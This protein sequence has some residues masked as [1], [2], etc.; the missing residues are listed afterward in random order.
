MK[1]LPRFIKIGE[2]RINIDEI[3]CY[4]FAIDEDDERYLYVGIRSSEDIFQYY[5]DDVDFDLE[6]KL[7]ELDKMFLIN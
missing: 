3:V 6:E 2:E 1:D 7:A 4:G 5:A